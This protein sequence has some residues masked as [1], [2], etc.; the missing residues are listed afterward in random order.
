MAIFRGT[1]GAGDATGGLTINEVTE[2]ATN[3]AASATSA[4]NSATAASTSASSA[5]TS[6]S[7]AD[8]SATSASTSASN[9][10]TSASAA[11]TSETNAA[12]SASAASASET[13]AA[14]S[15][16]AAATSESNAAASASAASTSETNA[17][18]SASAAS[19]SET[20][21]AASES[22]AATSASNAST[23]ESN[24]ATS[25][26]AASTS[27]SN[28]STSATNA[29]NSASAAATS[30]SEAAASAASINPDNID[31]NGGTIDGTTIGGTTPAAGTFTN[32]TATGTVTIPDNA[33]SGDKV[34]G[35][36]VNA[37]T[38][39]TL[40]SG[41][42][43]YTGTLTGGTGV[44]NIGSGQVYKDAS[45]NVGIGT[46]SPGY[47]LD[48]AGSARLN[49]T[50]NP[51]LRFATAGTTRGLI[52][53]SVTTGISIETSGAL[54]IGFNTNGAER[55][56]IDSSGRLL[57]GTTGVIA[58]C[59]FSIYYSVAANRGLALE[60]DSTSG[61][62]AITFRNP[63]GT[64]GTIQMSGSST[65]YNTSSDYRLKEN[66]VGVTG[67][68]AR[69]QQLN[70]VRFNFITDP[71]TTVDGFLAHEVQ[72]VVPEA[73]TGT[74]D[75]VDA[76]GNPEY[77]GID[78]SK[79]VPLLTAAL[80]EALAKIEDLTARVSALEGN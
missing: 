62:D 79:L 73:I 36:T 35:G 47:L 60:A 53:S 41:N 40:T 61:S 69:V 7:A 67:A 76:E 57:V 39:N 80:Q 17:A 38:I 6:A 64:V 22:A 70:P 34:E 31:I 18:N 58:D 13:A 66:V 9:A 72:D 19:T 12:A 48:V 74:K 45:G 14:A 32:L 15:E 25:A 55:A 10:A 63:N 28:A 4:A 68:S 54:H 20:N 37:I 78:Q 77:Q 43:A 52:T 24:A 26:S 11:S 44:V 16:S 1:G 8:T 33:I 21:A 29:A 27:A 2:Q 5:A 50:S 30:A 49:D 3:A 51:V 71:D 75:A 23:S 56:R 65:A 59:K 46:S 42:L